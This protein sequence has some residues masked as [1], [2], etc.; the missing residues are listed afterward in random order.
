MA[1]P[2]VTKVAEVTCR[3]CEGMW[4]TKAVYINPI[5]KIRILVGE[6]VPIERLLISHTTYVD[7]R[8]VPSP[9]SHCVPA[10]STAR[11][12]RVPNRGVIGKIKTKSQAASR[13][14]KHR[15]RKVRV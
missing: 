14:V 9:I 2:Y 1:L 11:S 13:S 12:D 10:C 4:S 5:G 8:G 15:N 7:R 6:P 3:A